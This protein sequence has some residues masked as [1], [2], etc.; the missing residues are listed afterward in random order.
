MYFGA[1]ARREPAYDSLLSTGVSDLCLTHRG[2]PLP[3]C[4]RRFLPFLL[5]CSVDM[6]QSG[7]V[8]DYFDSSDHWTMM[9]WPAPRYA[10]ADS[11]VTHWN[12]NP[13]PVRHQCRRRTL[14]RY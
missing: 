9:G 14:V 4:A 1:G 13:P 6:P 11:G 12:L 8:E 10:G 2:S 7:Q 3:D 5:P